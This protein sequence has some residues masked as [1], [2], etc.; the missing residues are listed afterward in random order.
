MFCLLRS[1]EDFTTARA[2]RWTCSSSMRSVPLRAWFRQKTGG[3][4]EEKW[5]EDDAQNGGPLTVDL[6]VEHVVQRCSKQNKTWWKMEGQ[7]CCSNFHEQK[8]FWN[9][10]LWTNPDLLCTSF[11]TWSA[12]M[13]AGATCCMTQLILRICTWS[14]VKSIWF[15]VGFGMWKVQSQIYISIY[16]LHIYIYYAPIVLFLH[17]N[18]LT[19]NLD[20]VDISR[21]TD[22]CVYIYIP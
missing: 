12:K 9:L 20:I 17:E 21:Y 18:P 19:S 11:S 16:I 14:W 1:S 15:G 13:F 22:I 5:W 10:A 6:C 3:N 7:Q 8:E 2:I 4:M